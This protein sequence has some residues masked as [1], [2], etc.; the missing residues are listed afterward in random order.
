MNRA[1]YQK[2]VKRK[3][4]YIPE[5]DVTKKTYAERFSSYKKNQLELSER[6]K[7]NKRQDTNSSVEIEDQNERDQSGERLPYGLPSKNRGKSPFGAT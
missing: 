4:S 6:K 5:K 1:N 7:C 2:V 3:G